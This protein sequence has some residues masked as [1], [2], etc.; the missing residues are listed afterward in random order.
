[1]ELESGGPKKA[2]HPQGPEA[3]EA[4]VKAGSDS[5]IGI[6][7]KP[8]QWRL[9]TDMSSPEGVSIN[10]S[11]TSAQAT[12]SYIG[13]EDVAREILSLGKGTLLAK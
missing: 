8:N 2:P 11:I 3:S 4:K 5:P 1:M 9:I 10:D 13:M 12:L 7:H 6:I